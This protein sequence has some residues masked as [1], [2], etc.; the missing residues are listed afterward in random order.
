MYRDVSSQRTG[1]CIVLQSTK[2]D[3]VQMEYLYCLMDFKVGPHSS[4]SFSSLLV[5]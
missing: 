3:L 5:D 1:I 2:V 4:V